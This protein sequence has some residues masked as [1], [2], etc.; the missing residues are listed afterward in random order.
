MSNDEGQV[1]EVSKLSPSETG[2]NEVNADG[3]PPADQ[4]R[5]E[6]GGDGHVEYGQD[7]ENASAMQRMNEDEDKERGRSDD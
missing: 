4:A 5:S 2:A 6:P 3:V 1:S 7:A